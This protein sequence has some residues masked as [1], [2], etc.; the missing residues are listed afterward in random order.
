VL[1]RVYRAELIDYGALSD[2]DLAGLFL[3]ARALTQASLQPCDPLVSLHAPV[4][5]WWSTER[6]QAE[7][8]R[9]PAWMRLRDVRQHRADADHL[10]IVRES[11]LLKALRQGLHAA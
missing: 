6:L 10:G 4:D 1:A 3:P 8:T 5:V 11:A 9:S 2:E 7:R